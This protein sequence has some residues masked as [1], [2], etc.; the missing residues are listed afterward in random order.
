MDAQTKLVPSYRV[1]KRVPE[2]A[3]G[4]MADLRERIVGRPTIITDGY[5]PY[6]EAVR[7]AFGR[8]HVDFAMLVKTV[9]EG[10]KP[11]REGYSPGRVV[12]CKAYP[13]FGNVPEQLISTSLIERQNLSVRTGMRRLTRLSLGFSKKLENLVAATALHFANYNLCRTHSSIRMT[14]AMA[15][16]LTSSIWETSQLLPLQ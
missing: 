16:G 13:V 3:Y 5:G 6:Y 10:R 12:T 15:A 1:G 2:I 14:P 9:R 7:D 4:L 8:D 11:V